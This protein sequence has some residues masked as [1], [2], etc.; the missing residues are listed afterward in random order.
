MCI[1]QSSS[2]TGASP[3]NCLVSYPG[4]SLWGVLPFCRDQS[5]YSAA[6]PANWTNGESYPSAERQSKHSTA[7]TSWLGYGGVLLLWRDAVVEFCSPQLT[8]PRE[9]GLTP[10]KRC[11]RCILQLV[12]LTRPW[13][14]LP[15]LK[16]CSRWILQPVQLTRPNCKWNINRRRHT[17]WL[18]WFKF[19]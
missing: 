10:L 19:F 8:R 3:L 9:R 17:K 4:H 1:P 5:A 18:T 13:G 14:V 16:R 6:P 15:P 12:Q 2:I 7:P 11:S